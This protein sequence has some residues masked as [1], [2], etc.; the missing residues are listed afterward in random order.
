MFQWFRSHRM[1][2]CM[3]EWRLNR[4][5]FFDVLLEFRVSSRP[6]DSA[7]RACPLSRLIVESFEAPADLNGHEQVSSWVIRMSTS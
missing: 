3:Y 7:V 4:T 6:T 1:Y 5:H 2:N